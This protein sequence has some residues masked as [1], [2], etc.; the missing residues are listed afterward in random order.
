MDNQKALT[1][2]EL[3]LQMRSGL[4][5]WLD[6]TKAKELQ[7]ILTKTDRHLFINLNGETINTA[8]LSGIFKPETI[9]ELTRRK[10]GEWKCDLGY[11]HNK[12]EK[13]DGGVYYTDLQGDFRRHKLNYSGVKSS[14]YCGNCKKLK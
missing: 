4:K 9:A 13:C 10:N 5:I 12:G 2:K 1:S 3:C 7:N 6:N 14:K 11:W 8:D